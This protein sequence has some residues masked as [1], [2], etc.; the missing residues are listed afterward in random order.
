MVLF[1]MLGVKRIITDVGIEL[2]IQEWSIFTKGKFHLN[3]YIYSIM[4]NIWIK[5]S[6]SKMLTKGKPEKYIK[7]LCVKVNANKQLIEKHK[8]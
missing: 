7:E 4:V 2:I 8:P 6:S 3:G 5:I 1:V